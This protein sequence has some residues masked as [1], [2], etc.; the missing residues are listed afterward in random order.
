MKYLKLVTV[1]MSAFLGS[2]ASAGFVSGK[3]GCSSAPGQSQ[4]GYSVSY[5]N[6]EL[7]VGT[8]VVLLYAARVVTGSD[9]Y[10]IVKDWVN[11]RTVDMPA[12]AN[13]S[14]GMTVLAPGDLQFVFQITIPGRGTYVDNGSNSR[15]GRYEIIPE[16]NPQGPLRCGQAPRQEA[17]QILQLN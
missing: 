1:L 9:G 2:F 10:S 14:W 15:W 16:R 11:P 3:S 4:I 17:V 13:S 6:Q 7:P 8:R 12:T 5:Y